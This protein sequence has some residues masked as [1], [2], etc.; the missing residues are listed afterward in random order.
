MYLDVEEIGV[1]PLQ[2]GGDS[3]LHVGVGCKS[4]TSQMLLQGPEETEITWQEFE[5]VWWVVQYIPL[6]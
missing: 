2:P 6:V 5:T 3:A 4:L 1:K